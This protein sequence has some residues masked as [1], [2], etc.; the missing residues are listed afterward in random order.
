MREEKVPELLGKRS[1]VNPQ[2]LTPKTSQFDIVNQE[3]EVV[4]R[5]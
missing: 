1:R 5:R 3:G 2:G 4:E